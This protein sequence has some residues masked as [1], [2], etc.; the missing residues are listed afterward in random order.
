MKPRHIAILFGVV[1]L[2]VTGLGIFYVVWKLKQ[3]PKWW[4]QVNKWQQHLH[5]SIRQLEAKAEAVTESLPDTINK[6]VEQMVQVVP[7]AAEVA[8]IVKAVQPQKVQ[9]PKV[10]VAKLAANSAFDLNERQ[11]KIYQLV[12]KQGQAQ[13]QQLADTVE[14]VTTRTLRRDLTK[15]EKLGL[16]EQVGKT[17]DSFYRLKK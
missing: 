7:A 17:K 11:E 1:F 14:G 10:S 8:Q 13:M 4:S 9:P 15:L 2:T 5:Q 3:Q 16:I 12:K 6:A